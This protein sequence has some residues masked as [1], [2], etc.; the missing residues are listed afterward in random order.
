MGAVMKQ[1]KKIL[2]TGAQG[3]IGSVLTTKLHKLK[4][5][6]IIA[7]DIGFF[8]NCKTHKFKDPVKIYKC[9]INKIN[10]NLLKN[11]YAVVHLAALVMILWEISIK[12]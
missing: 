4:K 12:T 1:K 11:V 9:D 7:T 8:K 2:V 3:F 6:Q 5:Y 10:E